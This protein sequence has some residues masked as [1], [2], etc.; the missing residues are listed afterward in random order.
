M[1]KFELPIYNME[2][3]EIKKTVQRN[4]VPLSLYLK[5]EK[6]AESL[7]DNNFKSDSEFFYAIEDLFCELFPALTRDEY[8]NKVDIAEALAVFNSVLG[9]S[10]QLPRGNSKNA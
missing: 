5:F 1:A 9:K 3:E 7:N 6:F 2:T 8:E 4:I 10:K